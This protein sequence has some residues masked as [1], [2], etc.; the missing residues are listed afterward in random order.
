MLV[1]K[2]APAPG[3]QGETEERWDQSRLVGSRLNKQQNLHLRLAL[4]GTHKMSR[5]L[6]PPARILKVY[7]GAFTGFSH[8]EDPVDLNNILPSHGC[9]LETAPTVG[10]WMQCTFQSRGGSKEPPIA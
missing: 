8:V 9:I 3:G 7:M 2:L 1:N 6:H 5:S 4:L 10:M